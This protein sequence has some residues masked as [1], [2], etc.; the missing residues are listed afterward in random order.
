MGSV[1]TNFQVQINHG[2]Q[3]ATNDPG[4][5]ITALCFLTPTLIPTVI[6][7]PTNHTK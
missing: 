7:Y 2:N 1:P 5:L 6:N 3:F 4:S